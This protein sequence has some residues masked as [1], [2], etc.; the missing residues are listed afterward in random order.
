MRLPNHL[1]SPF[2][3]HHPSAPLICRIVFLTASSPLNPILMIA[4]ALAGPLTLFTTPSFIIELAVLNAVMGR[5][6]VPGL[7]VDDDCNDFPCDD[8]DL[9]FESGL[10]DGR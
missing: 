3:I 6:D 2:T 8:F 7:V 4:A 10:E 1:S 5:P 9:E